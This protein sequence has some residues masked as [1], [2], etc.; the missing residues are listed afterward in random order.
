LISEVTVN[1]AESF[2]YVTDYKGVE[3]IVRI[4]DDT[5]ITVNGRTRDISDLK[6]DMLVTCRIDEDRLASVVE[7]DSSM[8]VV[9]GI[10]QL[11]AY[12]QP[13]K[14]TIYDEDD[15]KV[16]FD[17]DKDVEIYHDGK[18]TELKELDKN[19]QV[20]L[21]LDD[22]VVYKIYAI[23]RIKH[24]DGVITSIDYNESIS[25]DNVLYKHSIM[26][27]RAHVK[28]LAKKQIISDWVCQEIL[29]GLSIVE[30]KIEN[31]EVEFNILDED[32][33]MIIEKELTKE[34][35]E[36][37]KY[38]HTARSRND[39]N[40]L[41][42]TLFLRDA[43]NNS[44]NHL[45]DLLNVLVKKAEEEFNVIMPG[46]T[47]L[48]HA[49]PITAGYYY[50]AHFQGFR[51]NVERFKE[52][53]KRIDKNP[54]GACAMA[55][56]TLPIDRFITTELLDFSEPTENALDTVGSRDNIAEYLFN[57]ALCMTHLSG[58]AEEIIVFNSQEFNFITIDDSFCTGSSIMPQKK[59]PDI[60]EL[61][62]GKAGR[63]IGNLVTLLT[64]LKG[65][66]LTLNKDYQEDKE[67]LFDTIHTLDRSLF[68]FARMLENIRFNE[69]VLRD[70]FKGKDASS[71]IPES[72]Y[73]AISG[74]TY[75][76]KS[77]LSA[78]N[79]AIAVYTEYVK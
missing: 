19:D 13:A 10:I 40:A 26:G 62:R 56:T 15:D 44:I 24:Y 55:G 63:T 27:S 57:A 20:T 52:L 64:V 8:D 53:L 54:L 1:K 31:K 77:F 70:Q 28:M 58:F 17:V 50:I 45:M 2:I 7:A 42:E 35:G 34:I 76:S 46:F 23:S 12:V 16:T 41:D 22:G 36:A 69:E 3:S 79:N 14:I 61:V 73:D 49:Q 48:Q 32:I 66:F 74:A 65:T 33:M 25:F 11:V 68:V 38:L 47:H 67:A 21:L 39:Q 4:N 9:R 43:V 18:A 72:D 5:R 60:A 51:R 75:S 71:E 37:G 78:V 59:N 6:K 29:R 30:N